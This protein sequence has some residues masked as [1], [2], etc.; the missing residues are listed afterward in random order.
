MFAEIN[1]PPLNFAKTNL[2]LISKIEENK[3]SIH[4]K[5]L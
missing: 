4:L 5:Q 1:Y 2:A 3:L